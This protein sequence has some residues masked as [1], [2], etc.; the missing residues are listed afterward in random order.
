ME[1]IVGGASGSTGQPE[2]G[3][4]S[5]NEVRLQTFKS[6]SAFAK[7]WMSGYSVYRPTSSALGSNMAR[8]MQIACQND[9]I[10]YLNQV[11]QRNEIFQYGEN[12]T[13]IYACANF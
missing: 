7:G 2:P 1:V 6:V 12:S 4:Q 11:P 13:V 5:G 9:N 3:D 10:G 8:I